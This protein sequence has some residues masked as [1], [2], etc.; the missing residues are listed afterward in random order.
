MEHVFP[1]E[2]FCIARQ[3][4]SMPACQR[5]RELGRECRFSARR[6][7]SPLVRAVSAA[8]FAQGYGR[9]F[10]TA[11]QVWFGIAVATVLTDSP[12]GTA[13]R[14]PSRDSRF[15]EQA[16]DSQDRTHGVIAI[17]VREGR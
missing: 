11:T 6:R 16:P 17:R 14:V 7:L 5:E 10:R 1:V 2:C 12:F 15:S 8:R 3:M 4:L 9:G 13:A